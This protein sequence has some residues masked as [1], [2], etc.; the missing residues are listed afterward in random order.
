[1]QKLRKPPQAG[2]CGKRA[3]HLYSKQQQH[4]TR[5]LHKKRICLV[6][7][8]REFRKPQD[9]IQSPCVGPWRC[10]RSATFTVSFGSDLYLRYYPHPTYKQS[11]YTPFKPYA[12][13]PFIKR[14]S[15]GGTKTEPLHSPQSVKPQDRPMASPKSSCLAASIWP[16]AKKQT[17]QQREAA[18]AGVKA[19]REETRVS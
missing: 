14:E 19:H 15:T 8:R 7:Y 10:F 11:K 17:K 3:Q 5:C 4:F 9:L 18:T 16:G 1:M 12:A 2:F 6:T 13:A